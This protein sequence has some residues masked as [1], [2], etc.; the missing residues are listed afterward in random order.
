V[1]A[2]VRYGPG[3]QMGEAFHH[4]LGRGRETLQCRI[5]L[6]CGGVRDTDGLCR[7]SL[8]SEEHGKSG[9]QQ[10]DVRAYFD[11]SLRQLRKHDYLESIGITHGVSFTL[12]LRELE[13][14]RD[15]GAPDPKAISRR[16][17]H[18]RGT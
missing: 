5:G 17:F 4:C 16:R 14:Y 9:D 6:G 13:S 12:A 15:G 8:A 10:E 2:P 3:A 18:T 7:N 1:I 11:V